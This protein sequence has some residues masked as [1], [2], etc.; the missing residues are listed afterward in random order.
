M[1][2]LTIIIPFGL[3]KERAYIKDRVILKAKE[4]KSDEKVCYIFVEGYSST[5]VNDS[6]ECARIIKENGHLYL[7]DESQ[8]EY[9]LGQCRNF[10]ARHT[11]TPCMMVLD[12]DYILTTQNLK[13]I[14]KIIEIKQIHQNPAAFLVLPCIFLNEAGSLKFANK[15]LAELEILQDLIYEK[16]EFI[17]FFGKV[18]SSIVLNTYTYLELGGNDEFF[19]GH[20]YEDFDFLWRLLR[21]CA[22]FELLPKDFIFDAK[23]WNLKSFKGFRSLFSMLGLEASLSGIYL[24]H[25]YHQRPN[26]NNYLGNTHKNQSFFKK[27]LLKP[28]EVDSL[29]FANTQEKICILYD[30][31]SHIFRLFQKPCIFLG[32]YMSASENIFFDD[33]EFNEQRFLSF[34]EKNQITRFMFFNPYGDEKR[35]I[36]YFYLKQKEIPFFIFERGAF[37]NSWF[38]DDSGFLADSKNY[39]EILWNKAI[40]EE[41]LS[42]TKAYIEELLRGDS[43]LEDKNQFFSENELKASLGVRHKKVIFVPLQ[44]QSDTAIRFFTKEPFTYEG[45]L[46]ILNELAPLYAKEQVVFVCKKH[47]LTIELDKKAYDNL[48]FADDECSILSL[49]NIACACVCLN[50]GVGLYAMISKIPAVLCARAFYRFEGLNLEAHTKEE[51]KAKI[52]EILEGKFHFD[53]E[54]MLR[55]IKYLKE[56]FYSFAN[57]ESVVLKNFKENSDFRRTIKWNFY[58]I[59]LGKSKVLDTKC[60]KK[61]EYKLDSLHYL[62]F[63]YELKKNYK[64]FLRANKI[65]E[66]LRLGI[67]MP[68]FLERF[69]AY[70]LLRKLLK[71]PKAFFSDSKNPLFY[72]IKRV[73]LGKQK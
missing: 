43:F 2:L 55:F 49:L 61:Q 72:P 4:F 18:S 33:E 66:K 17:D 52:D 35:K 5:P 19:V 70:R 48:I 14:L 64:S 9:S 28:V 29:T 15:E 38:F 54:K 67:T 22:N 44:V 53:E 59:R 7:K 45:F 36:I 73:C 10:A 27:R 11:K 23:S 6:L 51:L 26:Q 21:H 47:P 63:A 39:D 60:F 20:G 31:S 40:N 56:D 41:E 42:R 13:K 8:K 65:D 57:T 46:Q 16:K 71:N 12:V 1:P 62:P 30:E 68:H 3:S 50:S 37:P 34:I 32:E 25:L 58:Q 24:Y 69:K